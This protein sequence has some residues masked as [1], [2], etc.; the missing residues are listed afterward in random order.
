MNSASA[1]RARDGISRRGHVV[2]FRR[3]TKTLPLTIQSQAD[4][5]AIVEGYSPEEFAPGITAG[6]RKIIV[7]ILDLRD[8]GFPLPVTKLDN[9]YIGGLKTTIQTIDPDH[10]EYQGCLEIVTEGQ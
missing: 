3:M 6:T 2:S 1:A 4:V 10:R 9:V 7:S 5:K 8:A